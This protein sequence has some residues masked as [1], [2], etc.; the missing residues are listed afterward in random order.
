MPEKIGNDTAWL[1]F[2]MIDGDSEVWVDRQ[3]LGTL[4]GDPWDKPKA[5][6]IP[7]GLKP[8]ATAAIRVRVHKERFAAG[9]NES[10]RLMLKSS[11]P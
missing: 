10:V 1:L 3:S 4:P 2:G 6:A 11:P 8:G 7:D 9:I 5:F